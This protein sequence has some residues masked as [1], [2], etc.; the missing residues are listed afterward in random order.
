MILPSETPIAGVGQML[1][2]LIL[3]MGLMAAAAWVWKRLQSAQLREGGIIKIL[4]SVSAS[5][6]GRILV[7]E[8]SDQW[9]VVGVTPSRM[10]ILA[11]MQKPPAPAF[12]LGGKACVSGRINS[13]QVT[14]DEA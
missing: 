11:T 3:V 13:G 14:T 5:P 10:D 8:V 4:G 6:Q 9:L 12:G 2:G 1:L 7:V